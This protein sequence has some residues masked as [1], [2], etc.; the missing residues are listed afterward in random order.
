MTLTFYSPRRYPGLSKDSVEALRKSILAKQKKLEVCREKQKVG[1]KAEEE[2]L[3]SVLAE[4]TASC[5]RMLQRRIHIKHCLW[6]ELSVV[7]HSRRAAQAT[8]GWRAFAK[9]K[10]DMLGGALGLWKTLSTRL[11][12]MPV[13]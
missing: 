4:E 1:W 10:S 7:L 11:E 5:E 9:D 13:E 12:T 3:T 6:H 8:L 2:K